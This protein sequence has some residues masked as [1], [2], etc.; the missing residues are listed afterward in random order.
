MKP[1]TGGMLRWLPFDFTL[2]D[3][4]KPV[5]TGDLSV[6]SG[7]RPSAKL[8]RQPRELY[9]VFIFYVIFFMAYENLATILTFLNSTDEG[10]GPKSLE[11]ELIGTLSLG[12]GGRATKS[13]CGSGRSCN[14][15]DWS[16]VR[17]LIGHLH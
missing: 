2:Q 15:L 11:T 14:H 7:P 6:S 3:V 10:L 16:K 13:G 12:K 1:R 8:T 17:K 4:Q 9:K 5:R